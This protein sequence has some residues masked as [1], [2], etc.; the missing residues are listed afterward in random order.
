[1]RLHNARDTKVIGGT[2]RGN[3]QRGITVTGLYGSDVII[4]GVEISGNQKEGF[5][6]GTAATTSR[7]TVANCNIHDNGLA[8]AAT[9]DAIYLAYATGALFMGNQISGANSRYGLRADTGTTAVRCIF[10][11]FSGL[12]TGSI[13]DTVSGG[14]VWTMDKDAAVAMMRANAADIAF[15]AQV[16]GDTQPRLY[17]RADG[18]M[19]FGDGA[20]APDVRLYRSALDTLRTNDNFIVDQ[21]LT[22]AK[23][24]LNTA[25]DGTGFLEMREQTADPA[26]PSVSQGRIFV[27]DNG[28]GKSQLCVRFNSG[29][30]QVIATE[31]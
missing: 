18:D 31:P 6:I 15:S 1:L 23:S 21:L 29:A 24:I 27:K 4:N 12:G 2:A 14:S 8:A 11:T 16:V 22:T 30:V 3:N 5:G 28:S 20:T 9:Y 10:N 19:R 17:V 13:S 26:A 7:L 25:T